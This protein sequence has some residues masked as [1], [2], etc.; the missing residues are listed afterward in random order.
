[1]TSSGSFTYRFGPDFTSQG[2]IFRLWAPQARSVDLELNG[3]MHTMKA[4]SQGWYR[5]APLS[6]SAGDAYGFRINDDIVVPDPAS[7][8]QLEDVHGPSVVCPPG[9]PVMAIQKAG[10]NHRWEETVLYELHTGTATGEGTFSALH[11]E[12]PRLK[13]LGV[14]AMELMPVADFPGSRNWGYDGVLPFAPDRAY[15]TPEELKELVRAAHRAQLAVWLDV[16]YNHFGPDGNYLH[17]YAPQFFADDIVTPWGPGIDFRRPEVRRFFIENAVYWVRE[18]GMDGLRFDA[19]HAIEDPT[20]RTGGVHILRE[21]AATVRHNAPEG[22]AVHLVLENDRNQ[23]S[24]LRQGATDD[25]YDGQ[26]NDDIHHVFHVL[27]TGETFGYYGDY[28]DATEAKLSRSLAEGYVYQGEVSPGTGHN[29]G[30]PSSRLSPTRFVSFLQNH[31]QVG[32]RAWGERLSR[33]TTEEALRAAVAVHL[34]SPQIPLIFMGEEMLST[35]PFLF[36]CD[37]HDDLAE[38]VRTGRRREFGLDEIPDPVDPDT[39]RQ[40]VLTP[41]D[42]SDWTDLYR[43]LLRLRK[44]ELIPLLPEM[45]SGHT[46]G[47]DDVVPHVYWE[48][49]KFRWTIAFNLTGRSRKSGTLPG[50]PPLYVASPETYISDA[51]VPPWTTL[52]WKEAT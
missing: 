3:A 47:G 38:A 25:L 26:W 35:R 16:V 11:N 18:F 29:R 42:R 32:N 33:L 8:Q 30:E 48:S 28:A 37:F 49:G 1:M 45:Q 23:S 7:R 34:L 46:H 12:I 24:F 50:S 10:G 2:V 41:E 39:A 31:D 51:P 4:D 15:G 9:V 40:C 17:L 21:L 52:V 19:V 43:S 44:E 6:S 14:T 22:K 36:F 27:L 5:S 20:V 13:G